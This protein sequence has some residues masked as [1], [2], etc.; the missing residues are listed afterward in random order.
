[1]V[2]LVSKLLFQPRQLRERLLELPILQRDGGLI[3]ERLQEPKVVAREGGPFRQSVRHHDRADDPRFASQRAHHRASKATG[4]R[5]RHVGGQK[6]RLE[7]AVHA[8]LDRVERRVREGH[9]H[10]G[11]LILP[12]RRPERIR[13]LTA[14]I[15]DDLR[16][17]GTEHVPRVIEEGNDRGVELGRVLKDPARLVE[18]LEALVFLVLGDIGAISKEDR[19]K[20]DGEQEDQHRIDAQEGDREKREARVGNRHQASELQHLRQLLELRRATRHRDNAGNRERAE[21][22]RREGSG[23]GGDPG[24]DVRLAANPVHPVKDRQ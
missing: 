3:R 19:G 21:Q 1:V 13:G 23:K 24:H 12:R 7:L 8:A 16:P 4:R 22:S 10:L 17:F 15:E 18:E 14:R 5:R 11:R 2:R 9:H 6:E 20:R